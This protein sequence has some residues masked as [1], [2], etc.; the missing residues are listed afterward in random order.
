M[1]QMT[2]ES[3]MRMNAWVQAAL[4]ARHDIKHSKVYDVK[5]FK[6]TQHSQQGQEIDIIK[7]FMPKISEVRDGTF[8]ELGGYK[9]IIF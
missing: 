2:V 9:V 4:T 8:V 7:N 3:A 5:G 6:I 1:S